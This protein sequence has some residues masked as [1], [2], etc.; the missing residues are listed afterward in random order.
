M[1]VCLA[2]DIG[3]TK[4][5]TALIVD[6][7]ILQRAQVSTPASQDPSLMSGVLSDL[8]SPLV[9]LADYVAVASTGIINNG[10]LTALNPDNLGGLNNFPLKAELEKITALPCYLINDAQAACWAEYQMLPDEV[11]DMAFITVSTGVGAGIVVG[12]ELQI[13]RRGIAGHAGHM[14][15]APNGPVCGCGRV[16]CV[17]VIASGTAIT[18]AG[19]LLWEGASTG[20]NIHDK[21]QSGDSDA[22]AIFMRSAHAVAQL[23]SNLRISLDIDVVTLGGSVGLAKGYLELVNAELDKNP[24]VFRPRLIHAQAGAD[25][26]LL[27]AAHWAYQYY[28]K[29]N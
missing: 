22:Q 28:N 18:K 1:S 2:I 7:L 15:A 9:K 26:G 20:K 4:I 23:I 19:Q 16:G 17:E 12:G 27:G 24:Q 6:G 5:A 14:Q 8:I 29:H 25:A 21:W 10:I 3:G 11:K 13:G